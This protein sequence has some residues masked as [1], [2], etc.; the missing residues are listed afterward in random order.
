MKMITSSKLQ[1]MQV[2]SVRNSVQ[3]RVLSA[4]TSL[5]PKKIIAQ[6][7]N[8]TRVL[9]ILKQNEAKGNLM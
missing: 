3:E 8:N 2:P 4:V 6:M 5:N 1:N 7:Y 9:K